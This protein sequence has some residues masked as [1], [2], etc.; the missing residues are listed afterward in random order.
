MGWSID[1]FIDKEFIE[2]ALICT[3]CTDVV[4]D[5]VQTQCDHTFCQDC[6]KRWLELGNG[7]CPIDRERLTS[8]ALKPPSRLTKQLHSKLMIRCINYGDGCRLM[9]KLEDMTQMNEHELNLCTVAQ[10]TVIREIQERHQKE[11]R[12][13]RK[14]VAEHKHALSLEKYL[15]S[16]AI[17]ANAEAITQKQNR[18]TELENKVIQVE[19]QNEEMSKTFRQK[20]IQ[21]A[22]FYTSEISLEQCTMELAK[23]TDRFKDSLRINKTKGKL[24]IRCL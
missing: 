20:E 14:E 18:I 12:E 2:D 19:K 10:N 7:T 17:E 22:D 3:I 6:I 13:L 4:K 16:S 5:P 15:H 1:R 24:N 9:S 11:V 21:L 23:L 8:D